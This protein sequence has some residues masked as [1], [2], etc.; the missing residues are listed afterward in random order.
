MIH[1][2]CRDL[3]DDALVLDPFAGSGTTL[4]EALR[5]GH[6]AIGVEVN[7]FAVTLLNAAFSA[8]HPKLQDTYD[9]IAT[10]ALEAVGPLYD[11]PNGPAGYFWAYQAPCSSCRETALLIKRTVIVQH[12]YPNRL[13]RGWALC[14]YDRNVFAITDV[15]KTKAKCTCCGRFIPLQPKRTGRFECIWCEEEVLPEP[16]LPGW[17]PE[18]V[19]VA[20]EIRNGDGVRL[21]R[22]PAKEEV[23]LAAGGDSTKLTRSPIDSGLTTEQ[24]L[25][26]GYVDWA[27]LLHPRQRVLA[28][29]I[30]RRVAR[31]EDEE[32]REQ[33]A[34]AFSPFFEY[35]CRLAS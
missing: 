23:A 28:S 29:A 34:L 3:G 35:H 2:A 21:F 24:I 20:V 7:P 33:L 19:L 32:L 13:P 11:G 1:E 30:S 25:R 18:P 27:D 5:L 14:P 22:Q 16:D 9:A 6:R 31:V 4:G 15:R 10:R 8:R 26:W 17:P 12:A